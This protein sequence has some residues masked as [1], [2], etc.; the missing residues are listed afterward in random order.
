MP[1]RLP[2]GARTISNRL[3]MVKRP[4]TRTRRRRSQ[5]PSSSAGCEGVGGKVFAALAASAPLCF[6]FAS[7]SLE[8][9]ISGVAEQR[10]FDRDMQA[11]MHGVVELP[12]ADQAGKLDDLR[13][14]QM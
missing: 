10:G 1:M 8:I 3:A 13:R 4:L 6:C 9:D 5:R 14:C 7:R 12:E 11:V 2:R